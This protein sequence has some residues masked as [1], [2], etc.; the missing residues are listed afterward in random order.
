MSPTESIT[1]TAP[2]P[3][4]GG[5]GAKVTKAVAA[6][7]AVAVLALGASQISRSDATA[8]A[9]G[10]GGAMQQSGGAPGGAPGG[11]AP[12]GMGTEVSG[13]TLTELG[14][15][16]TAKYPGAVERAMELEDGSYVV[17]VV[18]SGGGGEVHVRVSRDFEVTGVQQGG[19]PAGATGQPPSSLQS[20]PSTGAAGEQ[21]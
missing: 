7:V 3:A 8:G 17:H 2:A 5:A 21:S 9:T 20:A 18:R 15:A 14:A 6:V 4:A 16:A 12:P 1:P 19:P 10:A 11:M 13:S